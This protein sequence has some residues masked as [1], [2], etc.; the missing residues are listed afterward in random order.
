MSI[1]RANTV[2]RARCTL[3]SGAFPVTMSSSFRSSAVCGAS[4]SATNRSNSSGA[5]HDAALNWLRRSFPAIIDACQ[6]SIG[7]QIRLFVGRGRRRSHPPGKT[8]RCLHCRS[9]GG[10]P[11]CGAR[12]LHGGRNRRIELFNEHVTATAA[13]HK[14]SLVD[15]Y[16]WS[17]H[18]LR[19]HPELF[20][21][22]GFHPSALGYDAWAERMFPAALAL[23]RETVPLSA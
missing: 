15:L 7:V 5:F 18:A 23:L 8:P 10:T 13:R 22:D 17:R 9:A 3:A 2:S 11:L 21:P 6:L 20:S 14:L 12:R 1:K 4:A 19:G 16:G